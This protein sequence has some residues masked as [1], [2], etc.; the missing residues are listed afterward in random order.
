MDT[1]ERLKKLL[2]E[3]YDGAIDTSNITNETKLVEDIG[4]KSIAMLYMAMAIE[5]EFGVSLTNED[6]PKMRS[7][8]DIVSLVESR[9]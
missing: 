5:G 9:M 2:S 3:V 7:V 1:L 4:M 8:G 6:L